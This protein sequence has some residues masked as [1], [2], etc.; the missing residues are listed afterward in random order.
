M[1]VTADIP[2]SVDLLGKSVTDLQENVSINGTNVTGTLKYVTD[3]TGFS[4]DV[5]EQS[6]NY[7]AWKF[8]TGITGADIKIKYGNKAE[9]TL[10]SDG[11]LILRVASL[12]NRLRVRV[13]KGDTVYNVTT[14]DLSGLTLEDA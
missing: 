9:K 12:S 8:T 10:D 1:Q 4:G 6:G 13:V 14:F 7:L 2:A 3:Y 11:I 5:S